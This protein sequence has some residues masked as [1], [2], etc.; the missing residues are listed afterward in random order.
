MMA[1][2]KNNYP[3][4]PGFDDL[5][6]DK[7][8][9]STP[10]TGLKKLYVLAYSIGFCRGNEPDAWKHNTPICSSAYAKDKLPGV[11]QG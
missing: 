2:Q 1:K 11:M 6:W 7:L 9:E 5:N 10:E 3:E 8:K 4:I